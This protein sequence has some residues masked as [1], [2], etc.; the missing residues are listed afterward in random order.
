MLF[1]LVLNGFFC[2]LGYILGKANR[3]CANS[4]KILCRDSFNTI[5]RN[6]YDCFF[7]AGRYVSKK[8]TT[9]MKKKPKRT[10]VSNYTTVRNG[11]VTIGENTFFARSEWEANIAAYFEYLKQS[12]LI[13][14]WAHEP[15]T[16][17]FMNIKRG[18]RSYKPDFAITKTNGYMYYVEVKGFMDAKSKTKLKRMIKYYPHAKIDVIDKAKYKRIAANKHL[19]AYWGVLRSDF[20]RPQHQNATAQPKQQKSLNSMIEELVNILR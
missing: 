5:F 14:K 9:E 11:T 20:V 1:I 10:A 17:W 6:D 15:K 8:W 4:S 18:V 13:A 3:S 16:F 7:Y 19:I 2:F 12:G